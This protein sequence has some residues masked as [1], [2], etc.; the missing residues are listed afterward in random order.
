MPVT[1]ILELRGVTR[2]FRR[3]PRWNRQVVRAL[4]GID[5][6]VRTGE[7]VGVVGESGSGK[8]TLARCAVHLLAP[9][10]GSVL[11]EGQD[12]GRLD[13]GSL[14][15]SR[16]R[17]QL[18]PQDALGAMDPRM[19]IRRILLEPYEA[20]RLATSREH[21]SGLE[22]LLDAVSLDHT[23]L[24]RRPEELSGGQQQRVV[25]ARALALRPRLLIADEPVASLDQSVQAQALNL[26][27]GLRQRFG[28]TLILIS[29]SLPVIAR[30]CDRVIVM[31]CGRIVEAGPASDFFGEPLHP[32]S[33]LLLES[34]RGPA[35]PERSST[36]DPRSFTTETATGNAPPNT[37]C[38]FHPRCG[39][40]TPS[41]RES[42]PPLKPAGPAAKVACFLYT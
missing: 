18:I 7:R 10:S 5:L 36:A 25:M 15:R 3:G 29:H 35:Q 6:C 2:E 32:Y 42:I 8:S 23:L 1:D 24:D 34:V 9:T 40:A 16:R 26:L 41:C 4:A 22:E 33:R 11:F 20:H 21:A 30:T 39:V 17:F 19:T 37:G 14:R 13:R 38:A 31:Y 12:L 27:C 28:L